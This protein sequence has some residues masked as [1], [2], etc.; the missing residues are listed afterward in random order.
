MRYEE[1]TVLPDGGLPPELFGRQ[2]IE[3]VDACAAA[4]TVLI[5]RSGRA[6]LCDLIGADS[7]APQ[8]AD[9]RQGGASSWWFCLVSH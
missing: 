5:R 8:Q 6:G 9:G 7:F 3:A 2:I 4:A 1:P